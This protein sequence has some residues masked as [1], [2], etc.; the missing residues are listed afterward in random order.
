M[1]RVF[2]ITS[3]TQ[4]TCSLSASRG[5]RCHKWVSG[6]KESERLG[7]RYKNFVSR[8]KRNN[9]L[10]KQLQ[11]GTLSKFSKLGSLS[12]PKEPAYEDILQIS[13]FTRKFE[14]FKRKPDHKST[15]SYNSEVSLRP[16]GCSS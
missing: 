15:Y 1:L 7:G 5:F 4:P 8:K 16:R 2:I 11:Q 6:Y 14:A 13:D 3:T 10:W 9:M 12:K